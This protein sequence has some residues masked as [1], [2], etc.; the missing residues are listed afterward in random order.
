[1]TPHEVRPYDPSELAKVSGL[2]FMG[3]QWRFR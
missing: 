3:M 2:A 1:L